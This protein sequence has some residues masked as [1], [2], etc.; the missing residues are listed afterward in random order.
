MRL[1]E[2]QPE[3]VFELMTPGVSDVRCPSYVDMPSLRWCRRL[4]GENERCRNQQRQDAC[5]NPPSCQ[6]LPP[7]SDCS[8]QTVG[9]RSRHRFGLPDAILL[10]TASFADTGDRDTET[11]R[12][13]RF[14]KQVGKAPNLRRPVERHL[15]MAR[16]TLSDGHLVTSV[17]PCFRH[18]SAA[19]L[20]IL[21]DS[22]VQINVRLANVIC[23]AQACDG[24]AADAFGSGR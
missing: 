7:C 23:C 17:P 1:E 5:R 8:S 3:R 20:G 21:G 15:T 14:S 13:R 11:P 16:R 10:I 2:K 9:A 22:V 6:A 18:C 19:P 24:Y 12:R 4:R